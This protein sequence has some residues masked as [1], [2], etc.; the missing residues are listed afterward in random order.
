MVIDSIQ[1]LLLGPLS[2]SKVGCKYLLTV[3]CKSTHHPAAFPLC[4][5][6]TKPVMKAL[7]SFSTTFG[8][9]KVVQTDKWSHFMSQTSSQLGIQLKDKHQVSS[10]YHPES[11]GA[12]EHF[13]MF[14]L[15]RTISG[16]GGSI[17]MVDACNTGGFT[18]E[19]RVQS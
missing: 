17:A 19:H 13:L 8:F 3:T 15:Y 10:A 5:I 16:L 1:Y 11:Q 4:S 12:L 2:K 14:L 6:K 9:P 7:T 18:R